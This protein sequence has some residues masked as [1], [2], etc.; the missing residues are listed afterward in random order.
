MVIRRAILIATA[1]LLFAGPYASA[2]TQ[3]D[4]EIKDPA[5]DQLVLG[6]LPDAS[7]MFAEAD[8]VAVWVGNVTDEHVAFHMLMQQ[9]LVG[10][11]VNGEPTTHYAYTLFGTT[12]NGPF[13]AGAVAVGA[14]PALTPT[15]ATDEATVNGN[16]LTLLVP[17]SAFGSSDPAA[18][19]E[20]YASTSVQ[21]R[22]MGPVMAA[23]RAPDSGFGRDYVFTQ[24]SE[25]SFQAMEDE[26]SPGAAPAAVLLA[27]V[28]VGLFQRQRR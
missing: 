21:L 19:R 16:N 4:P 10:G 25:S 26:A 8:I 28:A 1:A 14:T 6:T 3:G 17:L 24:V 5:A 23:D 13:E 11:N 9:A 20:L 22:G 7:G 27:L 2:G 12:A 15:G 18:L